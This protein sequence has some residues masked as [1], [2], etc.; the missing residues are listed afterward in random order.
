MTTSPRLAQRWAARSLLRF[1]AATAVAQTIISRLYSR[2]G[3]RPEIRPCEAPLGL[4]PEETRDHRHHHLQRQE[5]QR[6]PAVPRPKV[7]RQDIDFGP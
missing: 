7:D 6:R 1:S 5:E 2:P 4:R 3:A